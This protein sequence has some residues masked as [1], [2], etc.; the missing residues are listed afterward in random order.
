MLL[1]EVTRFVRSDPERVRHLPDALQYVASS[2]AIEADSSEVRVCDVTERVPKHSYR[3]CRLRQ[4][5]LLL[6]V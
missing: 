1:R 5:R 4:D 3:V 6:V 2:N